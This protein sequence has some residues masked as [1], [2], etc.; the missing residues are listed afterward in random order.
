MAILDAH[1]A[2]IR[3]LHWLGLDC[4]EIAQLLTKRADLREYSGYRLECL[5]TMVRTQLRK[6][7]LI[8]FKRQRA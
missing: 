2:E 3:D 8:P 5:A 4:Y 6:L 7:G 1:N